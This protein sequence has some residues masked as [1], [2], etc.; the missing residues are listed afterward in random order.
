LRAF[1]QLP[2]DQT[3]RNDARAAASV[4]V[5][6][7]RRG[8]KGRRKKKKEQKARSSQNSIDEKTALIGFSVGTD[9]R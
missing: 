6:S 5:E 7:P 8:E 9:A 2:G 1:S 3:L 4:K